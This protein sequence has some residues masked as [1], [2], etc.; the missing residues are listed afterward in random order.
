MQS[1]LQLYFLFDLR[2]FLFPE[3]PFGFLFLFFWSH[4]LSLLNTLFKTCTVFLFSCICFLYLPWIYS[5]ICL[6]P[7][8]VHLFAFSLNLFTHVSMFSLI[9]LT[10]FCMYVPVSLI[11]FYHHSLRLEI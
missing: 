2:N 1:G 10:C 6:Y 3:F 7:L 5:D 11:A 8:W 9:S 4:S